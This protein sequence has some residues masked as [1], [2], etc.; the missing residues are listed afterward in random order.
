MEKKHKPKE[1]IYH[2]DKILGQ[3]YDKVERVDFVP[4]YNAPFDRRILSAYKLENAVLKVARQLKT[5]Y[6]TAVRRIMAQKE[7]NTEFE[8]WTT[9]VMSKP[10]VGSDYKVQE[11]MANISGDLK[12]RFRKVCVDSAGGNDFEHLGPFVAAMYRITWEEMQ[13][14]LAECR[15]MKIVGGREVPKRKMVPKYMPLISFPWLF[16]ETLGRIA[17]G[18]EQRADL[19]DL[20]LSFLPTTGEPK[21]RK[22][23]SSHIGDLEN[24]DAVET[25]EGIVHRGELLNIFGPDDNEEGDED[26]QLLESQVSATEGQLN[27]NSG[28][29]ALP[30]AGPSTISSWMD[31]LAFL[32][33]SFQQL[34]KSTM[35]ESE[36]KARDEQS[37]SNESP[38]MGIGSGLIDTSVP[39]HSPLPSPKSEEVVEIEE[40]VT[41]GKEESPL[42]KLAR[43]MRS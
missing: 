41:S 40:V 39:S 12:D 28:E 34:P 22:I 5:K 30:Q 29:T 4:Q 38:V 37:T 21:T 2:S 9:F 3:L 42:E 11:E 16:H 31:D 18:I 17:T 35:E 32:E 6:D 10:R 1:Q 13:I 26:E 27:D 15:T 36:G 23:G 25:A 43:L 14:A 20:G 8:V 19:E 24:D 7:I 33:S